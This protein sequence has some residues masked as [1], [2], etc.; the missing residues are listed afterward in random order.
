VL[1]TPARGTIIYEY[2][3]IEC[4]K[5][6]GC[7][8]NTLSAFPGQSTFLTLKMVAVGNW[9]ITSFLAWPAS[10]PG[11]SHLAVQADLG[12][13]SVQDH[14]GY[15]HCFAGRSITLKCQRKKYLQ[16]HDGGPLGFAVLASI[17]GLKPDCGQQR[18]QPLTT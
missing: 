12:L 18:L 11:R 15:R 3:V 2:N 16:N 8:N 5:N 17:I 13:V 4:L 7:G 10:N 9:A 14:G 6:Q 1:G